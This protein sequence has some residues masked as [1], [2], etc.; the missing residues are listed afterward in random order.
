[1]RLLFFFLFLSLIG[2]SNIFSFSF[3]TEKKILPIQAKKTLYKFEPQEAKIILL[4]RKGRE[5]GEEKITIQKMNQEWKVKSE[6]NENTDPELIKTILLFSSQLKI[7]DSSNSSSLFL[8]NT[9]IE[10]GIEIQI[11]NEDKSLLCHYILGKSSPWHFFNPGIISKSYFIKPKDQFFSERIYLCS[12]SIESPFFNFSS[13]EKIK[14]HLP[15]RT[16]LKEIKKIKIGDKYIIEIEKNRQG[17]WQI[18]KPLSLKADEKIIY[19]LLKNILFLPADKIKTKESFPELKLK[20]PNFKIFIERENKLATSLLFF[21]Q[22]KGKEEEI[23]CINNQNKPIYCYEKK[24]KIEKLKKSFS[25]NKINQI[26]KQSLL[27]TPQVNI[28]KIKI[29]P[30]QNPSFTIERQNQKWILK[31]E[32]K[33]Q[34][35][36]QNR[37]QKLFQTLNNSHIENFLSDSPSDIE[38]YALNTPSLT[39]EI[40]ITQKQKPLTILFHHDKKKEKVYATIKNRIGIFEIS[41]QTLSSIATQAYQWQNL[42]PW[43]LHKEEIKTI[44]I[45]QPQEITFTYQAEKD[46]WK[47]NPFFEI[48]QNR[49]NRYLDILKKFQVLQWLSPQNKQAMQ[50]LISPKFSLKISTT[51][52][53]KIKS[54]YYLALAPINENQKNYYGRIDNHLFLIS[55]K[56]YQLLTTTLKLPNI[57]ENTNTH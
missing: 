3:L 46:E 56:N 10:K 48:N 52:K 11:L 53:N 19:K 23:Y 45:Y 33:F 43:T 37:L 18:V 31:A 29:I 21:I 39:I 35:I 1:M 12:N 38:K 2:H 22:K 40:F 41:E 16:T 26:R 20:S 57:N 9:G 6:Y 25:L 24:L 50:A 8:K 27:A 30:K 5:K 44:Q 49:V 28:H 34:L 47:S 15:L 51:T 13:L 32:N 42:S 4:K 7:E 54:S 14:D 17:K 55:K 36:N